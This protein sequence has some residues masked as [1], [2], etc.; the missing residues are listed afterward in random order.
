MESSPQVPSPIAGQSPSGSFRAPLADA[1]RF[2]EPRRLL[3]NFILAAVTFT[4]I[5]ATWPHFRPALA[6][7]SLLPLTFLA[8][9]ANVCYS[10]A[11]VVDIPMQSS[12]TSTTR[13]RLRWG[14][15][16]LGMVFALLLENYWI[17]DEIYPDFH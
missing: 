10:V 3:Y 12:S 1:L 2:W 9:V 7:P 13:N 8:L 17:A 6:W 4:W 14:L 15:W 16:V 11:Y 5:V